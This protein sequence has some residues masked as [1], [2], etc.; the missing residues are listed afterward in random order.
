M[1]RLALNSVAQTN[2]V[3]LCLNLLPLS[4][5]QLRLLGCASGLA[6]ETFDTTVTEKLGLDYLLWPADL[7]EVVVNEA[8]GCLLSRNSF[9]C[10][11]FLPCCFF[12]R[13]GSFMQPWLS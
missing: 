12:P 4:L 7:V 6:K 2:R 9:V 13:H 8:G 3:V 11:S 5:M 1:S 10:L